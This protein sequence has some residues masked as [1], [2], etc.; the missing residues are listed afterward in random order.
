MSLSTASPATD[1]ALIE[2]LHTGDEHAFE[3]LFRRY[4]ATVYAV[5]LRI[6]GSPEEAEDLTQEV[7]L[8]LY[9]RPL[10]SSR[11]VNLAGWLYRVATNLGFNALRARQRGRNRLLRWAR[12]ERPLSG[13]ESPAEAAE[14]H[15]DAEAVRRALAGLPERDR[16]A[17][18]LRHSGVSYAEL[19]A[20]L[21][22]KAGSVG[23]ILVRAER[24][25]RNR[26]GAMNPEAGK[27]QVNGP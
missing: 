8:R 9:Q 17:L 21:G 18:V 11:D 22:V 6:T 10:P 26:Y 23:T 4:Y 15:A 20:A 16:V 1:V 3:E 7:F 27:E 25:L 24:A 2:A 5:L 12:L 19:A 14:R 13:Q